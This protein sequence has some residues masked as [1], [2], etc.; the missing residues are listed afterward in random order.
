MTP[1]RVLTVL[2]A[3]ALLSVGLASFALYRQ[4]QEGAAPTASGEFLPG[5][6]AQVKNAARIHIASHDGTFDIIATQDGRWVLPGR[7]N[8]P[9]D[10]DEVRHT[11]IGLAALETIEPKTAKPDWLHYIGLDSPPEGKGILIQVKDGND[12]DLASLI[13]GNMETIGDPNGAAGLFVRRPGENQSWLARAVFVPHGAPSDWMALHLLD[14][15]SARLKD[16][17][18]TPAGSKPYTMARTHPSDANFAL[19]PPIKNANLAILNAIPGIIAGFSGS[20]VRPAGQLDF[21]KASHVTA[22]SFDGLTFTLDAVMDGPDVWARLSAAAAPGAMPGIAKEA[23][24][25]N[26]RAAGW[27]YKMAPE[28]G[29]LLMAKEEMLGQ[30]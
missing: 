3:A 16:I 29:R 17:T 20:D 27:V 2:A 1:N 12:H 5:F 24:G 6:A 9:A 4:A 18:V 11:L 10:F 30:P 26:A 14:L 13:M 28:K 22:H 15:D 23:E 8:Y 21:A 19:S 25:I 7:G